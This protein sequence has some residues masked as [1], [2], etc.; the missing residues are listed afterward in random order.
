MLI[1]AIFFDVA[2]TLLYKPELIPAIEQVL[3]C[4]GIKV[5]PAKLYG[6]HKFLAEVIS[7]P[8]K[9]SATF[10]REFNCQFLLSLGVAPTDTLLDALFSACTYLPWVP[11]PDTESLAKIKLPIGIISNWD[12]SL[13]EKLSLLPGVHF[14]WVLGSAAHSIRKPDLDFYRKMLQI[15]GLAPSELI[16]VGDSMRL[17]I[18]PALTLGI[19]A[20][21]L[22]REEFYGSSTVRRIKNLVEIVEVLENTLS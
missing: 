3:L 10:Y 5:P 17:D 12:T 8:D 20:V 22:D 9:T 2:N 7:F 11:F 4:H 1:K 18:A 6:N 15:S 19:N 14:Q 21:L 16:Y 13:E